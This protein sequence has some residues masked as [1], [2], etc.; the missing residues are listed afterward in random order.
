MVYQQ[1]MWR[2]EGTRAVLSMR[3][4]KGCADPGSSGVESGSWEEWGGLT[5]LK[6][7]GGKELPRRGTRT[8]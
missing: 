4:E 2:E 6:N 5:L 1:R 8:R 7:N 3:I